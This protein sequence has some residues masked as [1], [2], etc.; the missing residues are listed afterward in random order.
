MVAPLAGARIEIVR[1][2]EKGSCIAVAPLA[3]ARIE[4]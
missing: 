3:G 2:H 1:A 4:I